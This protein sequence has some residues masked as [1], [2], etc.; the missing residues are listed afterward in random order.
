MSYM[1]YHIIEY[2]YK[3]NNVY[4]F[5]LYNSEYISHI[6]TYIIIGAMTNCNLI[7]INQLPAD[8]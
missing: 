4:Y 3:E 6:D 2:K 7:F 8:N 1:I 5:I